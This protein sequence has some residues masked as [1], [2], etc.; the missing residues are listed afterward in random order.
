[1]AQQMNLPLNRAN[2][3]DYCGTFWFITEVN[4]TIFRDKQTDLETHHTA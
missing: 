3:V 1:M 4:E 2:R